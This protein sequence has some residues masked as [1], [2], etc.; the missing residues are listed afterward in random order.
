ME[1]ISA[2]YYIQTKKNLRE[3]AEKIAREETT[4]NWVGKGKPTKLFKKAQA[5]VKDVKEISPGKGIIEINFPVINLNPDDSY[6]AIWLFLTGG[7]VFEYPDY[8][9]VR[10]VDFEIP[11]ILLK[12]FPGPKFGIKG[13]R[14]IMNLKEDDLILGTIIKPCA[15]LTPEEVAK[16]CYE[17]AIGGL[18]FIKDDEKMN[19]PEY[20]PLK[21]K[22]KLVA[23]ALKNAYEETGNKV[24]YAP[25]ITTR[26]DKIKDLAKIA[27]ECGANGLMLNYLSAGFSSLQ[28]LAEDKNINVPIY[29]HSGGRSIFSRIPGQGID[30]RVI[31]KF[32]RLCGGDYFQIGVLG[33]YLLGTKQE[34][35][36]FVRIFREKIENIKDT[37]PVVAGGLTAV[38][39]VE[40]I[41]AF[42]IDIMALAGTS[43]LNHPDGI[44]AGVIAF[45]Q[46]KEAYFKKIP[47]KEYAKEHRELRLV[48]EK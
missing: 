20:C 27:I 43:I 3:V 2:K 26:P 45:K 25:H 47:L 17:A 31:A 14:K 24:I 5:F 38:N 4:G 8:Q 40:N 9:K 15:G 41:K 13:T 30:S 11:K 19:N 12:R 37:V 44:R 39:L 23:K 36:E 22:V 46:A 6:T 21:K 33:G 42:G 16:K 35:L 7:P 29:A 1:Y 32:V 48:L 34:M 18:N 28:I 10:L